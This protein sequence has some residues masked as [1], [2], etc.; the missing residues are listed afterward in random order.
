MS[1]SQLRRLR[2]LFQGAREQSSSIWHHLVSR[3]R[4]LTEVLILRDRQHTLQDLV[5]ES[6]ARQQWPVSSVNYTPTT[7]RSEDAST[8]SPTTPGPLPTLSTAPTNPHQPNSRPTISPNHPAMATADDEDLASCC[9]CTYPSESRNP[10]AVDTA[11][12]RGVLERLQLSRV[13]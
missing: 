12:A 5:A 3:N 9:V 4:S 10:S 1:Q 13:H 6:R 11:C 2:S 7:P 8:E